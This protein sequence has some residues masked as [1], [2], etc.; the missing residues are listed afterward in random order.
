MLKRNYSR[1]V[2]TP[3]QREQPDSSRPDQHIALIADDEAIICN[4]LRH[5]LESVGFFVLTASDGEEALRISREFVGTI[6]ILVSDIVM[7]KIDGIALYKQVRRERPTTKVLLISAY[8]SAPLHG[9]PFLRKPFH[10][11]TFRQR[12]REILALSVASPARRGAPFR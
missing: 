6:D 12:V 5:A 8:V 3:K 11:D 1:E 2:I 9:M 10:L 7:P 4:A